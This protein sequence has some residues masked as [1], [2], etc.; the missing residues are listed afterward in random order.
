[1]GMSGGVS[2]FPS[3]SSAPV[4]AAGASY[5]NSWMYYDF[6]GTPSVAERL[7]HPATATTM[8]SPNGRMEAYSAILAGGGGMLGHGGSHV[9]VASPGYCNGSNVNINTQDTST[10]VNDNGVCYSNYN[11]YVHN[12]TRSIYY[13]PHTADMRLTRIYPVVSNN[14]YNPTQTVGGS[15]S[16]QII[17][18]YQAPVCGILK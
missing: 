6:M 11:Q 13:P 15:Y 2:T 8:G 10:Y 5:S 17:T 14:G 4:G 1:M 18:M 9:V 16:G 7:R 3:G 12:R